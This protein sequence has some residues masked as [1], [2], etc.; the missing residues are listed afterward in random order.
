MPGQVSGAAEQHVALQTAISTIRDQRAADM[1][2]LNMDPKRGDMLLSV[3][4]LVFFICDFGP[5]DSL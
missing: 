1:M 3:G 4:L 2:A 5:L